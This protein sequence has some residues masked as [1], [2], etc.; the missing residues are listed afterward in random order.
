VKKS[1][2]EETLNLDHNADLY[3][4][5]YPDSGTPKNAD[6]DPGSLKNEGPD[7][8]TLQNEDPD[9]GTLKNEDPDPGTS[10]MWIRK[11]PPWSPPLTHVSSAP[12]P[13]PSPLPRH[14][15]P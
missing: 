11:P 2:K 14:R 9:P 12:S 6:T 1:K 10:K 7:P 5:A 13:S 8:G 4:K 15:S 3:Q